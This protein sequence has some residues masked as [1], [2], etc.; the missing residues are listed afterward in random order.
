MN[1]ADHSLHPILSWLVAAVVALCGLT[2]AAPAT[3]EPTPGASGIGDPYYPLDGNGG[4]DAEHY[5]IQT[6]YSLRSGVLSG[7]TTITA[8]AT[9]DLSAFN[10]DFLLRTLTVTVDGQAAQFSKPDPHELTVV[11]VQPILTGTRFK[12]TVT[13]QGRPAMHSYLGS[14]SWLQNGYEVAAVGEP[15]IAPWWFPSND[16]PRDKATFTQHITT[17]RVAIANGVSKPSTAAGAGLVTYHFDSSEPMA[18]YLAFFVIGQ[19]RFDSEV[20]DG[21]RY[22]YAVSTLYRPEYRT[23]RMRQLRRT[24]PVIRWLSAKLGPYPFTT[25]GGVASSVFTIGAMETQSRP[26]YGSVPPTLGVV[27]HENA[28]QWFGDS[29]SPARWRDVWLNEGFA[30]FM[31]WWYAE[32]HGGR[33]TTAELRRVYKAASPIERFWRV[34]VANPLPKNLFSAPVYFRGAMALAAL[35]NRIGDAAFT[36]LLRRWTS[37]RRGG[38]G[39]T[40]QFRQLAQDVSGQDLGAFFHV[41][42]GSTGRPRATVANGF[43]AR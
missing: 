5:D 25:A 3:G 31:Q 8:V 12:V 39:T 23:L 40:E 26:V 35:R 13:Y 36:T 41:W 10:L 1:D 9:Q 30:E 43:A 34:T 16:H 15:H 19:F 7:T 22:R 11:P 4:Y 32:E 17:A 37:E 33:T 2:V 24:R 6:R 38:T 29:V 27:V 28:H 42:V 14:Y 20:V 21:V 18:T